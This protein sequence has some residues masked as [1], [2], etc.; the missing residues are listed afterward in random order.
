MD[1][2]MAEDG[3][4]KIVPDVQHLAVFENIAR[5]GYICFKV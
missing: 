5:D 4:A 1:D 3:A 2:G